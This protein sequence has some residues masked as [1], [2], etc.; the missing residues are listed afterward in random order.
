MVDLSSTIKPKSDQLNADDLISGPITIKVTDVTS[1][2]GDQPIAINFK[3]DGGKPFLPCKSMRRVLVQLWG[4]DG[5]NYIGRS[6]TLYRD[7]KVTWGGAEVGGIR[8]SHMS[9]LDGDKTIALTANKSQRKP[10]VVKKLVIKEDALKDDGI[11]AANK[12]EEEL[13]KWFE[14][15]TPQNKSIVKKEFLGE[16][17]LIASSKNN[18]DQSTTNEDLLS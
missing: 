14:T 9:D 15:L 2:A 8:I 12:G 6:M 1:R 13:K 10:Y 18:K 4:S 3:D 7:Q 11:L 16:L 5:K 17:K